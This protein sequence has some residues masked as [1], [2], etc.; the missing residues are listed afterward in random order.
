MF[1]THP[2]TSQESTLLI[3]QV[4]PRHESLW[5]AVWNVCKEMA[6]SPTDKQSFWGSYTRP[7]HCRAMY[8]MHRIRHCTMQPS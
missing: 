2:D 7:F 6:W 5:R 4:W 8:C 3:V 1:Y